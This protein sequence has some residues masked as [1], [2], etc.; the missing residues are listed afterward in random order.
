M[1]IETK[2]AIPAR[3]AGFGHCAAMPHLNGAS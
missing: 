1:N 3:D 2:Q